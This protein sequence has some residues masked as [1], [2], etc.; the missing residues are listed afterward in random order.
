[1]QPFTVRRIRIPLPDS[2]SGAGPIHMVA[3]RPVVLF[4]S[5]DANLRAVIGR[6]LP[7]EG[8]DVVTA[9]HSGHA[10]LACLSRHVD[11]LVTER[12]LVQESGVALARRL[13]RHQPALRV[14]YLGAMGASEE[15]DD[16][17]PRPFT[18]EDLVARLG[19]VLQSSR[20]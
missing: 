1:M 15:D 4:V 2:A 9:R 13:R 6:V 10:L 5:E 3:E 14:V 18:S 11:I 17:L 20:A 8:Y 19:A 12:H 16:L 7:V